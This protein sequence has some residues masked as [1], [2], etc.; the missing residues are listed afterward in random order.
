MS[1][2]TVGTIKSNS[3]SPPA[4]Q[5]SSGTE[6]GTLCRAWVNFDG[7]LATPITP[8]ASFN[9]SSV[10]KAGTGQYT[11]NFT[12]A[13]SNANYS[14][15]ASCSLNNTISGVDN[16][17]MQPKT[18]STTSLVFQTSDATN[19]TLQDCFFVNVAIFS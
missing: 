1:T 10:T 13:M 5:N 19:N 6:I 14:A 9:I 15:P 11:I 16:G 18:Y 2:L 17:S 3:T 7:T 12:T 4:I 8:R